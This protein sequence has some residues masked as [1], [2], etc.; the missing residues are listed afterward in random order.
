MPLMP[1][2]YYNGDAIQRVEDISRCIKS[3][4]SA[5]IRDLVAQAELNNLLRRHRSTALGDIYTI[6]IGGSRYLRYTYED[7]YPC[8]EEE[9][10]DV[11]DL[12]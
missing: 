3:H 4:P 2:E 8:K 9:L 5:S 6:P 12:L 10:C 1:L 11:E 7:P